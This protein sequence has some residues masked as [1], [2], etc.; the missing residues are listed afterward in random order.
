M[1]H[2]GNYF[3]I[4]AGEAVWGMVMSWCPFGKDGPEIPVGWGWLAEGKKYLYPGGGGDRT[5]GG[6]GS[7]CRAGEGR[8]LELA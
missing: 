8:E 3:H 4:A 1:A 6:E 2:P 5:G 7:T